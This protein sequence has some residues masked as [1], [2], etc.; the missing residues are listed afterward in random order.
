MTF[1]T[2]NGLMRCSKN[3]PLFDPLV[4]VGEHHRRTSSA[5]V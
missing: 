5:F 4:G 3:S 1:M 2:L